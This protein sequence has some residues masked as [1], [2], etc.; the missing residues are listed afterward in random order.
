MVTRGGENSPT[1]SQLDKC[2]LCSLCRF[3]H[4]GGGAGHGLGEATR[5]CWAGPSLTHV[6]GGGPSLELVSQGPPTPTEPFSDLAQHP[7]Q[8]G[9]HHLLVELI[10]DS[11]LTYIT[12]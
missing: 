5:V 3:Q 6:K 2:Q 12:S 11:S 8:T 9:H 7:I 10:R 1:A 4:G